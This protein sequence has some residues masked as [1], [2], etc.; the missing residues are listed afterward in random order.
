MKKH[1]S[2]FVS[3]CLAATAWSAI[4]QTKWDMPTAYPV[5]A[6]HT[7]NNLQFAKAV[8]L[9][10]GGKLEITIHANAS[11]FKAPEIKRAVQSGQAQAGEILL[12]NFAN[13]NPIYALDGVPFLATS[14]PNAKSLYEASKPALEKL[15]AAQNMKLL[16]SVPWQPRGIYSKREVSSVADLRGIKWRAYSPS[17][18]RI[19]QLIG[20]QSVQV[21]QAE[22]SAAMATGVIESY[23]SS[24]ATGYDTRTYESI[25]NL[26][27]TQAWLPKNAV[28]V[29]L[30]SFNVLDVDTQ[31][32]VMK[33]AAEAESRGW[34][35]SEAKNGE[36]KRL[37][38]E[39]GMKIHL[40]S[41][42]LV[43][44]LQ[45]VGATMLGE[46]EK[47]AGAEGAAIVQAYRASA[48]K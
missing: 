4:A 38:T 22:L 2:L 34:Q 13:E 23:M 44:D 45:Q 14:Y 43:T 12:A 6:F 39:R 24:S 42:K 31:T 1:L 10:T 17:T 18:A 29:N 3:L 40:P 36:Y 20:A 19:A 5:S 47:S 33:A 32:A 48:K 16:Y 7:E 30:K 28:I 27:D 25:K 35:R 15:L 8:S 21:Q 26:Y 41:Q 46:W 37:L 11:L 9:A